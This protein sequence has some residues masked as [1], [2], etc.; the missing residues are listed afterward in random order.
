MMTGIIVM[1]LIG[2]C[3]IVS[4]IWLLMGGGKMLYFAR[5]ARSG[6]VYASIPW[7]VAWLI[8]TVSLVKMPANGPDNT[9]MILFII[10]LG[11]FIL[12]IVFA[13]FPP[14]ILKPVWLRWLERE[15]G[16]IYWL[17]ENEAHEMGLRQWQKRVKTQED[18]EEWVAE[19]RQKHGLGL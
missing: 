16:D 19:V 11:V 14:S 7:G 4:G 2:L 6:G 10:G 17:L 15:H 5:H 12:G 8:V 9:T 13:G 1:V 3:L 18:L